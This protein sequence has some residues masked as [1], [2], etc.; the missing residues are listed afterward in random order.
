MAARK[1]QELT[2]AEGGSSSLSFDE[3]MLRIAS[4]PAIPVPRLKE[5]TELRRQLRMD[6]AIEGFNEAMAHCQE[7]MRPIEADGNNPQTKSKYPTLYAVDKALR[8]IYS[9]HGFSLS[10]NTADCPLE[11]HVRVLCYVSRGIYTRTYQHDVAV[12]PKGPKG[13]D[14]M[15]KTHAG[16]SALSHGKRYL[17]LMIFNVTIGNPDGSPADD[18]GNAAGGLVAISPVQ[19]AELIA[20]ADDAGADKQKFCEVMGVESFAHIPEKRFEEAKAQLMRKL[21]QRQEREA[22]SAPQA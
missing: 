4:N 22:K 21:R 13:N 6:D 10:F 7:E 17:E 8:P 12:D 1:K 3:Q 9:K 2:V 11:N 18:D 15:T 5:I 14:V 16:G 20:L 19:R